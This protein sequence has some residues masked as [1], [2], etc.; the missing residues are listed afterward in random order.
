MITVLTNPSDH[1]FSKSPVICELETDN[2]F[3][4]GNFG[5]KASALFYVTAGA[6]A[7]D[8]IKLI[9][10]ALTIQLDYINSTTP[11][12]G[13]IRVKVVGDTLDI[14]MDKVYAD[15]LLNT[16]ITSL[17]N[18][19]YDQL[20]AFFFN[21]ILPGPQYSLTTSI[22]S[23]P[24]FTFYNYTDGT[25]NIIDTPR[26]NYKLVCELNIQ[27][28][29]AFVGIYDTFLIV[30]KYPN[31]GKVKFD[32]SKFLDAKLDYYFPTPNQN[33]SNICLQTCK[34]FYVKIKEYYGS[35]PTEQTVTILPTPALEG[36]V[37]NNTFFAFLLKAGLSHRYNKTLPLNQF[38]G[39]VWSYPINLSVRQN[40]KLK[41]E[42][43]E[44]IYF[45]FP[46][47]CIDPIL[48]IQTFLNDG[49]TVST[50]ERMFSG[51]LYEGFVGC[52]PVNPTGG[53]IYTAMGL[54]TAVKFVVT[55]VADADHATD[56]SPNAVYYPV[57]EALGENKIFLYTNSLGGVDTCRTEGDNEQNIEFES[58]VSTR[59]Y[60]TSDANN[61]G[62][63]SETNQMQQQTFKV[64]SGWLTE[65]KIRELQDLFLAKYKVEVINY[66]THI[67]IIITSKKITPHK[68]N[69]FLKGIEFE[70]YYQYKDLVSDVLPAAI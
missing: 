48:K 46:D 49:T 44:Y 38:D 12:A 37:G 33:T 10:T 39:L 6:T 7:G 22:V 27:Q 54:G 62:M 61:L 47:D 45:C 26:P 24:S 3:V 58:E 41:I 4:S 11:T 32:L 16:S 1:N 57:Y 8:Y 36:G 52:F 66:S 69:E 53:T 50:Y 70:Y 63:Y 59:N 60:Y 34:K 35:P 2:A 19:T 5:D 42:Q 30:E 68:T 43:P 67:P 9:S 23:G 25:D 56:I 18:V 21:S 31:D 17:Y 65:D 13:K 64:F 28:Q 20:G 40:I 29:A 51:T 55:I 15:I 14:Y